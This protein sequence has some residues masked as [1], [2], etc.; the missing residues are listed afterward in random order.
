LEQYL[1]GHRRLV[2]GEASTLEDP[3]ME[4]RV[5]VADAVSAHGLLGRLTGLFERP[6]VSF[7]G[8]C[9]EVRVCSELESRS[10]VEVI[11]TVESWLAA[12]RIDSAKLSVGDRSYTMVSPTGL[13][14]P[15]GRAA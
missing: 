10:I 5:A 14:P 9:N 1:A 15:D 6:S 11:G 13:G 8:T 4:I 3:M 12:D 7:D 2:G